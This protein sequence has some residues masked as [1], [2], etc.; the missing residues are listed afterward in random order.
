MNP[1]T[2]VFQ[3]LDGRYNTVRDAKKA[4]KTM[5]SPVMEL[6]TATIGDMFVN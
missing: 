6:H 5:F 1:E 2:I 4:A 3:L